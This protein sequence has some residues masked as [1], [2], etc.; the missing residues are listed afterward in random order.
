MMREPLPRH[1]CGGELEPVGVAI[2]RNLGLFIFTFHNIPGK[3]CS[4]CATEVIDRDMARILEAMEQETVQ[5]LMTHEVEV[6][7]CGSV[8]TT[9][10]PS[11]FF[12]S[13]IPND[14]S[15]LAMA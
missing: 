10:V 15:V 9:N 3:R 6:Q 13:G 7:H 11:I 5:D 14:T 1:G 8:F 2:A 12:A 4:R